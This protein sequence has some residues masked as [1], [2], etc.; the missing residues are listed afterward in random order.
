MADQGRSHN[1]EPHF[2]FEFYVSMKILLTGG[3]GLIGRALCAALSERHYA[4][5]VFSRRPSTVAK[6]CGE[7]VRAMGSPDEWRRG[8]HYDAV[9]NLAGEPIVGA[10]W[11]GRRKKALWDSRVTLTAALLEKISRAETKPKV[12]LSGSAVGIYGDCGDREMDENG[13]AGN[14]FGARLCMAWEQQAR[15]VEAC[16]VRVCLLRTG[17]VLSREGGMFGRMLPPFKLGLGARI[18]HGRQWMSWVHIE[19]QLAMMLKL[20]DEPDHRGAFNLCAPNPV[21]NAVFTLS[22]AAAVKRPALLAVPAV[23]VKAALGESA[24]LLLGGQKV[25]PTRLLS[26]GYRFRYP[27]LGGAFKALL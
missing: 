17:L 18:A 27:E 7:A 13:V 23:A 19:D 10:R 4:L 11:S 3:T 5:T 26:T 2:Q 14:D 12:L 1:A 25:L 9:I 8:D 16:G 15:K 6:K 22:L 21:N 24:C 20:L